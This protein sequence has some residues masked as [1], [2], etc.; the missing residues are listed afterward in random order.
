LITHTMSGLPTGPKGMKRVLP[1]YIAFIASYCSGSGR[2]R[3]ATSSADRFDMLSSATMQRLHADGASPI[4]K[5]RCS[6][7]C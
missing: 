3:E 5:R 2:C 1:L 7:R 6:G 4:E